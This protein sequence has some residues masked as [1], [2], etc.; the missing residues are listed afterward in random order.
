MTAPSA[1]QRT[2]SSV[3]TEIRSLTMKRASIESQQQ[4]F[5]NRLL[6]I[7]AEIDAL[8]P[9]HFDGD[10]K[11]AA[12]I[13]KLEIEKRDLT[14]RIE[15]AAAHIGKFDEEIIPLRRKLQSLRD[16]DVADEFR[17]R[18]DVFER[19]L[20]ELVD[21]RIATYKA[22][23]RALYQEAEFIHSEINLQPIEES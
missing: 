1:A 3:E 12:E 5:A 19:R 10:A 20:E 8:K 13:D 4:R 22:A 23:C 7:G 16:L 9:R 21:A 18:R 6:Q 15:G 2:S 17:R 11:A 14:L